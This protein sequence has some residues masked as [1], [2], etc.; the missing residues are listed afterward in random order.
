VKHG[1]ILGYEAEKYTYLDGLNVGKPLVV[2]NS[3]RSEELS[4]YN[5]VNN[6]TL[7]NPGLQ[8]TGQ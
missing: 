2:F 1:S 4:L 3:Q 8:S 7:A 5:L 6:L